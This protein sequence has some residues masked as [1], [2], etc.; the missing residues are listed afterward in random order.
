MRRVW[1]RATRARRAARV[2]VLIVLSAP[3]LSVGAAEA[4]A[5]IVIHT[6]RDAARLLGQMDFARIECGVQADEKVY[7]RKL[8]PSV[9]RANA[10]IWRDAA[11][12]ELAAAY[13]TYGHESVC[14]SLIE[15]LG[16]GPEP[17]EV[18]FSIDIK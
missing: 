1:N 2:T 8:L 9:V 3:L 6:P 5:D 10:M 14:N 12:E 13:K 4:G 18:K 7:S 16:I 17:H 15:T 11:M